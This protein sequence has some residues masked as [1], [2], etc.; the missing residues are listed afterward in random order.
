MRAVFRIFLSMSF[1]GACL[2]LILFLVK[3]FLKD[4][5]SRQWQY[6]IWLIV[7][8]RLLCPFG[9]EINIMEEVYQTVIQSDSLLQ[10]NIYDVSEDTDVVV[11]SEKNGQRTE[12]SEYKR[13][14][15]NVISLFMDYIWL[16]WL[17]VAAG[18]MIRKVTIYQSFI[19]YIN[20]GL[21]PVSDIEILDRLAV[22]SRQIGI[23]KPVELCI[24]PLIA[25]PLLIGF[26]HPYIVLPSENIVEKDFKYI[27]FHELMHYKRRDIFY[28]WLVQITVCLHWFNPFVHLMGREIIKSCEFSCD[29]AV[30]ARIGRENA[31][32]YGKTLLDAMASVGKYKESLGAVTLSEN[33]VLL[34][35]R[36][37]AIMSFRKKSKATIFLT[38][39]LTLLIIFGASFIGVYPEVSAYSGQEGKRGDYISDNNVKILYS[40]QAEKYYNAGSLP[41]FQIVFSKLDEE[42]QQMWLNKIY[43]DGKIAFFS[44][45]ISQLKT[46]GALIKLLAE[47]TYADRSISFFSVLTNRMSKESLELWLDRAIEDMRW[48]FQS[49]LFEKL[50]KDDE[51]DALEEQLEMQQME[52]YKSH[53]VVFNGKECYYKNQLVNI[54]MDARSNGS[55]YT[56]NINPKGAVNIK[57]IRNGANEITGVDYMTETEVK[58]IL[59][60]MAADDEPEIIPVNIKTLDGGDVVYLGEYML[61]YGD[62]IWYDVL[63]ETGNG[64]QVGFAKVEDKFLNTVYYSTQNLRQNGNALKCT[65]D[66]TFS[67]PVKPGK[68]K[69]FIRATEDTLK[70][71]KGSISIS[72]ANV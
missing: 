59:E 25:S 39:T 72:Y 37:G 33:K 29:E 4:K 50:D 11:S 43:E 5:I 49:V 47:K 44:V 16:I 1:T 13:S 3:R 31:Q 9:L 14:L 56:L 19:R 23:K 48:N 12:S 40:A 35:E 69:L 17:A 34:K 63:A 8:L 51:L 70:N 22:I 60:D 2:I 42:M 66:I 24:N 71:V 41:L 54:F 10:Q 27:V 20:A 6:Y 32:D 53:G 55:F 57:I 61:S 58:E 62:R 30:V 67:S 15:W 52:E 38:G 46:D 26:F 21:V 45:S 68:Y 65:A 18:F 28:K 36:L 7:I 64:L